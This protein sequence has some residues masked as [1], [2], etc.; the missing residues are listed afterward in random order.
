MNEAKIGE[1][2]N[3]SPVHS[4]LTGKNG[5]PKEKVLINLSSK[6][7]REAKL[8]NKEN[9]DNYFETYGHDERGGKNRIQTSDHTL[10]RNLKAAQLAPEALRS[11]LDGEELRHKGDIN[12]LLHIHA[13]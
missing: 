5:A 10:S 8:A 2:K 11:I 7:K 13:A 6:R 3:K 1:D 4:N 9:T 12:K